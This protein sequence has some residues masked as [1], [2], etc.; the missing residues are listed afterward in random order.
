LKI[1]FGFGQSKA[2]CVEQPAKQS[3][4]FARMMIEA[5]IAKVV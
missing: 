2:L 3:R 5:R 4:G 1:R